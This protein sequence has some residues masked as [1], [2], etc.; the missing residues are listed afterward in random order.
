MRQILLY[1]LV[2][3][4]TSLVLAPVAHMGAVYLAAAIVLGGIFVY[5]AAKLWRSSTPALAYA[6]LVSVTPIW[7]ADSSK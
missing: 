3:F 2:L 7:R 1:S 5:R 4:A 6:A